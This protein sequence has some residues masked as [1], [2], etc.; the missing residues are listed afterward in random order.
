MTQELAL[1]ILKTGANVFLTGEPGAGKTHTINA[2]ISY[3]S[4]HE[5][6]CAVTASTGIAAT[7]IHGM[8]IHSWS[9]IGIK[10]HL[11]AYDLDALSS[12]KYV[13]DR[14]RKANV[15]I[16]DEISMLSR[17]MFTMVDEVCRELRDK[18]DM[19]FGG[20][21]VVCVGDFFQLPP[22]SRDSQEKEFAFDS[23][24]WASLNMLVCYLETQ[25]RQEDKTFLELLSA[26]RKN[27]FSNTHLHTLEKR[28]VEQSEIPK[29][30]TK[31]FPHN[32]NVD[33][34]NFDELGKISSKEE[35]F[36][37]VSGGQKTLVESLKK[38]C[39]S[40]EKL[41]LKKGAVV[42]FT[43]NNPQ[44][45]FANG[46]LGKVVDFNPF[47]KYP[48]VE[49]LNGR[50]IEVAPMNWTVE[51][52]GTIKARITQTPLRLAWA[53]TVHKSQ[54]ISLD[55]AVID[56]SRVFEYG[57]GYVALSRV[58]SLEGLYLLGHN[59]KAFQV[60]PNILEKDEDFKNISLEAKDAFENMD[61]KELQKM[62]HN[63]IVVS[64]GK[65]NFS[66]EKAKK[67]QEQFGADKP[68]KKKG[69]TFDKTRD[70]FKEGKTF[71]QIAK[72]RGLIEG[73]ILEHLRNLVV[74]GEI[75]AQEVE[76]TLTEEQ[77]KNSAKIHVAFDKIGS[78]ALKPVFEHFK[79]EYTY[80]D[81]RLAKVIYE[82]K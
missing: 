2:F 82:E 56:L 50:K 33:V 74:L 66:S 65:V 68:K 1:D 77:I 26:I 18:K 57:Q 63:F 25:H 37:M 9:G 46:S 78:G 11:T 52:S 70:L 24:A 27:T 81:L 75:T 48:I 19:P 64:G 59:K 22:I 21:Q 32:L 23:P 34:V 49:M 15:L 38:N 36:E 40:P 45:K 29:E 7:H 43:K 80:N 72:I 4:G 60:H 3:V 31:L 20:L 41:I 6:N 71:S 55:S 8:T 62:H 69:E 61:T 73:T 67:S 54:G 44:E 47:N 79:G 12:N 14:V 76:K 17:N 28:L 10:D 51:D 42:M 5:V 13:S 35:L 30:I 58:R 39:L 53:M 16:I